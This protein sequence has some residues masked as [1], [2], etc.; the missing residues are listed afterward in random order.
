MELDLSEWTQTLENRLE[1]LTKRVGDTFK[2]IESRVKGNVMEGLFIFVST[3]EVASAR[4][5]AGL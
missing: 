5:S 4:S 1:D 2:A 3:L